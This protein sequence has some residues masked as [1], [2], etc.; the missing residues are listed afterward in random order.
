MTATGDLCVTG[1][2]VLYV[3]LH[4]CGQKHASEVVKNCMKWQLEYR[5]QRHNWIQFV[6]HPQ[7]MAE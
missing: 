1:A 5:H 2:Y 6:S 4:L 7:V 3:P